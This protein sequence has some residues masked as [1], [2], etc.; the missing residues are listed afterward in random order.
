MSFQPKH[1]PPC[2]LEKCANDP[3]GEDRPLVCGHPHGACTK[4]WLRL[5]EGSR[6]CL[7]NVR[8]S[9]EGQQPQPGWGRGGQIQPSIQ[10]GEGPAPGTHSWPRCQPAVH[11]GPPAPRPAER[12]G[13]ERSRRLH[14]PEGR[15]LGAW[16]VPQS[17]GG[18]PS[19]RGKAVGPV[20]TPDDQ[21][22]AWKGKGPEMGFWGPRGCDLA[23]GVPVPHPGSIS[24]AVTPT[25][26][27]R[28][29]FPL[30]CSHGP[31]PRATGHPVGSPVLLRS[32]P[33]SHALHFSER[34]SRVRIWGC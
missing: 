10:S 7:L 15:A 27:G 26:R 32:I 33:A 13:Q 17:L 34:D 3:R 22:H 2:P 6:R 14:T 25:L 11:P 30:S 23:P 28:L 16:G 31:P 24:S 29:G 5:R 8:E 19:S 4:A 20:L 9:A 1:P 21:T 18:T 12:A